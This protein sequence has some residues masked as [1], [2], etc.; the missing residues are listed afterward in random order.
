MLQV[1]L[2]TPS[3]LLSKLILTAT[4]LTAALTARADVEVSLNPSNT[5]ATISKYIYGQFAEH[6]GRGIYEGIYVGKDSPIPNT[7]GFRNDVI[8]A[9]RELK[10][11]VVR[12]PGGCFAD[13]YRWRDGIGPIEDRPVR[14]N[15]HW[16]GVEEPNTF[17]THEFFELVELIGTEAYIAGNLGSGSPREMAEW[18]EY[19]VSDS[20]STVAN[21]R[22][23]NGRDEPWD[24]AF[25]GV[26]NESWGC[27]GNMTAEFYTNLYRQFATFLKA[28][29]GKRPKLVASGSQ[30]NDITWTDSLSKLKNN[31]DGISHHYYTLPTSDWSNKGPAIGFPEEHWISSFERTLRVEGFLQ[32]QTALLKKNNPEGTIGLYLDEWGTWFD[33]AVGSNPGFLY[34]QN[35]IR[36]AIIAAVNFNIFHEYTD[37]LHMANIAQMVNVLQAMVLTDKEKMLLTPTYHAFKMYIPFQDSA[38]IPVNIEG[39]KA[40]SAFNR[41]VPGFS[42]S[43]ARTQTG[44]VVIAVVNINPN[45]SEEVHIKLQASA[46]KGVT[47]EQLSA[48]DIDA[49]NTFTSPNNVVPVT[50]SK[51]DYKLTKKS[52]TLSLTVP[53]KSVTV[54]TLSL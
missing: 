39:D 22:R 15:T 33:P 38:H 29:H 30:D 11:P 1:S 17:G 19:M 47:G 21:E 52:N 4:L 20:Q 8:E 35:S 50:L 46:I 16:G 2:I 28:P 53:A 51:K 42:A 32:E 7:N 10:V 23:K 13:E 18:M 27:G 44:D 48:N 5:Q 12:W 43:A 26:G 9:L 37:R 49:H 36:D 40:Y 45:D 41:T 24:V 31:I 3:S 14:V 54:L 25:W 6:L 34:Q